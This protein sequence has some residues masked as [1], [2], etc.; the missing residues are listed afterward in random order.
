LLC[1]ARL[2]SGSYTR[3]LMEAAVELLKPGGRLVFS[4]CTISPRG[5]SSACHLHL[6]FG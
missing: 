5:Y 6:Q 3:K 2:Q 4:T 1:V